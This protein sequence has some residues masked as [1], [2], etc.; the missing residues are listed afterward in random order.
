MLLRP[1]FFKEPRSYAITVKVCTKKK[2]KT[3]IVA[4]DEVKFTRQNTSRKTMI[5]P[6]LGNASLETGLGEDVEVL[7]LKM[8]GFFG[9]FLV[10]VEL[11]R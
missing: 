9:H 5:M 7:F 2:C 4:L 11:S 3:Q 1:P 6:G 10:C 8:M